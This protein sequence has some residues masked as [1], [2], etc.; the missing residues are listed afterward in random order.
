MK[1]K[2]MLLFLFLTPIIL[3]AQNNSPKTPQEVVNLIKQNVTCEW[4]SE[5]VDHFKAGDPSIQLKGI[6]TCITRLHL[7]KHYRRK[8]GKDAYYGQ[9]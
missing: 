8:H 6:A 5:T 2:L 3:K 1:T 4:A 7:S 9:G